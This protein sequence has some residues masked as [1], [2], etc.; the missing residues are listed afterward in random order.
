MGANILT[1]LDAGILQI[2]IARREKK[3]ALSEA[4]YAALSDAF[5]RAGSDDTIRVVLLRGQ[6]DLFCAGNDIAD[7]LARPDEVASE[8]LRFLQTIASF[9]KPIIAAVA[10]DAIGIGTTMLLHCDLVYCARNARFQMPFVPLGLCPEGAS[11]LLLPH[12]LGHQHAAEL[13]FF[14]A[15]F[16]ATRAREMR[17]V[18]EVF[19]EQELLGAALTRAQR[20]A[21]LPAASLAATKALLRQG[22]ATAVADT[23]LLEAR[24]FRQLLAAPAAR[25]SF[26]AFLERRTANPTSAPQAASKHD[27]SPE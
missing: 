9:G 17:L 5:A 14:G 22:S 4:M 15:P 16:D 1:E 3:N 24:H 6:S 2:E 7:F 11:S 13:L 20:L 23:L 27:H 21:S 12:L 19:D 25:E 18:N 26:A 10:G 8:A